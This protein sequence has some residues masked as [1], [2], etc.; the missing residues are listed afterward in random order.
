MAKGPFRAS[1]MTRGGNGPI[2][3]LFRARLRP[4]FPHTFPQMR[5]PIQTGSV[6]EKPTMVT[7]H[8]LDIIAKKYGVKVTPFRRLTHFTPA[9]Y[10]ARD[11]KTEKP[12]LPCFPA[13]TD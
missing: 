8:P 4:N 13:L 5:G 9:D 11:G 10:L 12:D 2:P 6:K 7:L 3:S 1:P